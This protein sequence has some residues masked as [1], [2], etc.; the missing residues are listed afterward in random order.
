LNR[1]LVASRRRHGAAA[2]TA[3]DVAVAR[4]AE[5]VLNLRWLH[6]RTGDEFLRDAARLVFSQTAPR[7]RY[8]LEDQIRE[9]AT[10]FSHI[11][12]VVNVAMA[13]KQPGPRASLDGAPL[14]L[15]VEHGYAAISRAW[16]AGETLEL[17][18]P[19]PLRVTHRPQ[20]AVGIDIGL[21][22]MALSAGEVWCEIPDSPGLGDWEVTPRR[23]WNIAAELPAGAMRRDA[24]IL[25]HPVGSPPFA[26]AN[27]AV[28]T[29]M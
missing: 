29:R 27:A 21:L 22:P 11:T 3:E 1:R 12:H 19:M 5:A 7:K 28:D 8:M 23:S 6:R 4:G 24:P 14:K 2:A 17:I 18:L 15:K 25:R 9:P 10:T 16:R 26:L 20:G 13:I